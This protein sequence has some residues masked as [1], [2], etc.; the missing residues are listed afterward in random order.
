MW[1]TVWLRPLCPLSSLSFAFPSF[2]P[3]HLSSSSTLSLFIIIIIN[4]SL[5]PP[6]PPFLSLLVL[7]PIFR[8]VSSLSPFLIFPSPSHL[9]FLYPSP[10]FHFSFVLPYTYSVFTT[11]PFVFHP[12][13][14]VSHLPSTSLLPIFLCLLLVILEKSVLGS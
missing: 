4:V 13:S 11:T 14:L 8:L 12:P 1:S 5:L 7:P 3:S 9:N 10:P 6:S 2:C